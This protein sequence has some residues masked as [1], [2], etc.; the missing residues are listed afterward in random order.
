MGQCQ[1]LLALKDAKNVIALLDS[2]KMEATAENLYYRAKALDLAGENKR[3]IA[4]YLRI[5]SEYPTSKYS[6]L[7]ERGFLALSPVE[8]KG[9]RNYNLRLKRA[10]NLLKANDKQGANTI[11]TSLG[12]A[13]A[14]DATSSQKRNLLM[15][16]TEYRLGKATAAL[17]TLKK[18]K[19]SDPVVHAKT[20][21]LE[22]ACYRRLDKVKSLIALRDEALKL[23]P[24]SGDTEELCYLTATYYDVNYESAK[25][26]EAYKVLYQ[27]FPKGSHSQTALQKLSFY[28]YLAGQY[29]EAVLGFYRYIRTY[30]E[31]LPVSW[32]L[33]WIGRSYEKLG[34]FGKAEYFYRR[35]Q[36]LANYSYYGRLA[37]EA[38][39][40]MQKSRTGTSIFLPGIDFKE[41]TSTCNAIR[42]PSIL[43]S[44]PN[45]SGPPVIERVRQL[46]AANLPELA[47]A[48]LRGGIRAHPQNEDLFYLAMSQVYL[49][50]GKYSGTI[51]CLRRVIPDY[52]GRMMNELP[53]ETWRML[54]PMLYWDIISL[55]AAKAEIDPT[56]VLGVIRQES[57]FE[58]KAKS[59]S[60]ARGL[61]QILPSTG[62][63]LARKAR[64]SRYN[65]NSL[66]HAETNIALGTQ[67]L[68]SLIKRY[69][70]AELALAAYNAGPSRAD[71]WL[72][73]YGGN[74]MAEFV[75]Q[76]PFSETQGYVKKVLSNK[77]HYD[78]LASSAAR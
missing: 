66:Y 15:A 75:E 1:A 37:R 63:E 35:T 51:V 29:G 42:F 58:E 28:S 78:L 20:I 64:M 11:L 62:R 68:A 76:I 27:A 31:P 44:E 48:E 59:K 21:Y 26:R 50:K 46:V 12:R 74:D 54:F 38:E 71:R 32:A 77:A 2:H 5:Y 25:S 55:H 18:V 33:F 47:L 8:L 7:A 72:R 41:V 4:L 73:E 36:M 23:H 67:F 22:A 3:A 10:E 24:L 17:T 45:N 43:M 6:P 52:S 9:A 14:P 16:E 19:S 57:S 39:V 30:S 13:Q 49:K 61:M 69:G 65:T 60:N 34:D 56:L 40:T 53:E 70:K